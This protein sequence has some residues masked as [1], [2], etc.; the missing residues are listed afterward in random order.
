MLA[1]CIDPSGVIFV[2]AFE[3]QRHLLDCAVCIRQRA[4]LSTRLLPVPRRFPRGERSL[5]AFRPAHWGHPGLDRSLRDTNRI[6][7]S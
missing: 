4:K 2:P 5:R 3:E 1:R 7:N 6:A